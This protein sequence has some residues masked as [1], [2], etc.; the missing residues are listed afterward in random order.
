MKIVAAGVDSRVV[1]WVGEFLF[2]RSQRV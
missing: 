2:G 1:V